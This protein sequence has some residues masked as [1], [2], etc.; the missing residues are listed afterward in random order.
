MTLPTANPPPSVTF[1]NVT[2][3]YAGARGVTDM[4]FDWPAHRI[5]GVLGP[6]GGG[7]STML[8]LASGLLHPT[9]GEVLLDGVP[10]TGRIRPDVAFLPD[11]DALYPFYTVAEMAGFCAGVFPAFDMPR[12]Q[13]LL[14]FLELSPNTRVGA[15]SK[16]G[17]GRLKLALILGRKA[18]LILMDEP[19]SGLDPLVR[20]SIVRGLISFIDLEQ[21]TIVLATHEVAEVEPLL[22]EAVLVHGGRIRAT[23]S[24]EAIHA[25]GYQKGLVGWMAAHIGGSED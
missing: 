7:K 5:I 9:T 11:S 13:R 21:Q 3:L 23:G 20:E 8:K 14:E 4:S 15:L 12:V 1:R 22:D 19:L 2:K 18:S 16:G 24:V 6:N 10:Q 17:K 25:H